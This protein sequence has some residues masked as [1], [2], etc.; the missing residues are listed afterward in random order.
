MNGAS[1]Y[2]RDLQ[3]SGSMRDLEAQQFDKPVFYDGEGDSVTSTSFVQ[4]AFTESMPNPNNVLRV[5]ILDDPPRAIQY[6]MK[7]PE[8]RI[9]RLTH[10]F[11][12][13]AK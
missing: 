4:Q 6:S 12:I 11:T 10:G 9:E 5:A 3:R 8:Q 1:V 2:Y 7:I 13:L